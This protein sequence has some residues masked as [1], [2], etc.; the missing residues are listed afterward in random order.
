VAVTGVMR[1]PDAVWLVAPLAVVALLVPGWRRPALWGALVAGLVLGCGEWVIE[2]YVRY[3][4][5]GERL[6]RASAI[7]GGTGWNFAVDDQIRALDGRTLCR[8][9]D[10]P[11]RDPIT[12]AWWFAL[13]FLAAGGA[14]M[15]AG[16]R[17][18][19]MLLPLL[20]ASSLSVPYLFLIGYA[21]PRFLLPS[22]ALLSLPVANCLRAL[23]TAP[24]GRRRP[25][26]TGLVVAALCGHLAVQFGTM[27]ADV[28]TNRAMRRAYDAVAA[29]LH[30]AGV[31]PPCVLTGDHA[32]PMA[33]YARCAS[34]QIGGPDG[35]ITPAALVA[36]ARTR[37]V[38][39]LVSRG[40]RPPA[41]ARSWH[42]VALPDSPAFPGYRGWIAP[43]GAAGASADPDAP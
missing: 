19:R 5:V 22:Y 23:L 7:Q 42:A 1:P 37:P 17:R 38:A 31:R 3:G 12:S 15:P 13:P 20:V 28:R 8:P 29:R 11:W 27:A 24:A 39:V 41:F 40:G 4:G 6:H 30:A 16:L 21:A 32:V 35:S 9:C 10:A 33:F 43:H 25:L 14:M 36:A 18:R 34:R 2:A 26:L